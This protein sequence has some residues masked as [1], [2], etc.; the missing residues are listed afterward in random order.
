MA[1]TTIIASMLGLAVL[2]APGCGSDTTTG[3][4]PAPV[5]QTKTNMRPDSTEGWLYYSF[6]GD[7][8]VPASKKATDEWDV[9]FAYL[10]GE[11]RTRTVDIEL[12]SG[13]V[14]IGV[15]QGVVVTSRFEGFVSIDAAPA[16]RSD[17]T[18]AAN[19][20]VPNCVT[21]P[22]ALFVYDPL[23]H[24]INPSPDKV[25]LVRTGKGGYVKFQVTSIYKD[26]EASP[27][28]LTPMGYYHLR[29]QHAQSGKF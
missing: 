27:T 8:I 22:N 23:R 24:T 18:A 19:R 17:D 5:V 26:A 7:S 11:G 25:V 21:C 6:D 28:M 10:Q 1:K 15:T 9:R 12:N 29:Y 14:G 3:P 13:T 2:L 4:G 16:L 20:V